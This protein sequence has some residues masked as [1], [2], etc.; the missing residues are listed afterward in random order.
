MM[1]VVRSG[2][3]VITIPLCCDG[4]ENATM[5]QQSCERG[6]GGRGAGGDNVAIIPQYLQNGV[7]LPLRW[8]VKRDENVRTIPVSIANKRMRM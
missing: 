5:I 8:I 4:D 1:A 2:N 3:S 6:V 7:K